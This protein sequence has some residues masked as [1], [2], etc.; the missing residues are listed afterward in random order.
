[1]LDLV[2]KQQII[3]AQP[4]FIVNDDGTPG[5][6][7]YYIQTS[8][9]LVLADT[10]EALYQPAIPVRD[11]PR[12]APTAKSKGKRK[13]ARHQNQKS[14]P[15]PSA[16]EKS[17]AAEAVLELVRKRPL[18]S[19]ELVKTLASQVSAGSVYQ[20]LTALRNKG[21]VET[22]VDEADGERKNRLVAKGQAA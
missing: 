15:L 10:V 8:G 9:A 21:V 11:T 7:A 17:S 22:V 14:A 6:K 5:A 20:A 1:M 13:W 18:T 12:P 2:A 3:S 16:V 4:V 19:G